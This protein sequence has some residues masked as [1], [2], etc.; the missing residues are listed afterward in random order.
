MAKPKPSRSQPQSIT[1]SGRWKVL[2]PPDP[3]WGHQQR[4]LVFISV[5]DKRVEA[6]RAALVLRPAVPVLIFG[7]D[8]LPL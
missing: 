5:D 2:Y 8:C 7:W 3:G 4:S 6:M 1:I